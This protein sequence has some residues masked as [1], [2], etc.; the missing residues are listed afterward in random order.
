MSLSLLQGLATKSILFLFSCLLFFLFPCLTLTPNSRIVLSSSHCL[1][2]GDHRRRMEGAVSLCETGW[3]ITG[4]CGLWLVPSLRWDKAKSLQWRARAW[5]Q[6]WRPHAG[7]KGSRELQARRNPAI[8]NHLPKGIAPV[9]YIPESNPAVTLHDLW[10]SQPGLGSW[11]DSGSPTLKDI[12]KDIPGNRKHSVLFPTC[13]C[14]PVSSMILYMVL[15]S[16]N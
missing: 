3:W 12:D 10:V 16:V 9:T 15:G 6:L 8:Y 4:Q 1:S 11:E 5:Q 14:K 2:R 7:G 13:D